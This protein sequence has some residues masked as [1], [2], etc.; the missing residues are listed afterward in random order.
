MDLIHPLV[1]DY[2]SIITSEEDQ[3]LKEINEATYTEH[4]HPHMLSGQVQGRFLSIFSQLTRP[5][6]ILEIGT[7]TG[8]SALCLAEGLTENGHLHTI[9]I[10]EEDAKLS[11]QNI[12][13]SALANKI[14]VHCGNALDII[15]TLNVQWDIVFIDADKVSY[16]SY[17]DLLIDRLSDNGC[18]L[19]DNVLFHGQIFENPIKGKNPKAI[20]TFNEYVKNDPRT[21]TVLL[22]IRDGLLLIKKKKNA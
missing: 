3:L 19:A 5:Q 10:R 8:Y 17:Y 20:H 22:T 15:P 9:E 7:F 18:I 4:A 2:A 11:K 12:S 21:E 13:K 6:N 14:T 16:Q 1:E